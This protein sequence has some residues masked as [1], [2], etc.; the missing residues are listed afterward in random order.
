MTAPA[1]VAML[2]ALTVELGMGLP[3][4]AEVEVDGENKVIRAQFESNNFDQEQKYRDEGWV[5][6][7]GGSALGAIGKVFFVLVVLGG[8]GGVVFW[9]S[10]Q[11]I[12][13]TQDDIQAATGNGEVADA[14]TAPV[15]APLASAPAPA[16]SEV[17]AP[18]VTAPVAD[19]EAPA[20]ASME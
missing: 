16:V 17:Q 11:G 19:F 8:L 12:T 3:M 14:P 2:M 1:A 10:Q 9:L 18:P 15:A 7:D 6:E 13:P 20:A 5:D 4:P